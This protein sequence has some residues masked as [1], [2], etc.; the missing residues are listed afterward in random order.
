MKKETYLTYSFIFILIYI[1]NIK[2]VSQYFF[3][4]HKYFSWLDFLHVNCT[5]H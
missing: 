3:A 5:S 1:D 4:A 2:L